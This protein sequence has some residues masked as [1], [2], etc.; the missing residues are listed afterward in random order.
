MYEVVVG[1]TLTGAAF[2]SVGATS[3]A[4]YDTTAT[5]IT[6]GVAIISGVVISGSG[7]TACLTSRE[8]DI[9]NPLVISQI[10]ALTA[11]QIIVSIVCTAFAGTSNVTPMA[12]WHEQVI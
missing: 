6:G 7:S 8:A 1:G 9:R 2:A 4:E 10:D 11:N 12:N 5:T 3:I